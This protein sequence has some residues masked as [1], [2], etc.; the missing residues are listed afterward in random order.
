LKP[1]SKVFV[2]LDR[3]GLVIK[4]KIDPVEDMIGGVKSA[5]IDI[6][7]QLDERLEDDN[8]EIYRHVI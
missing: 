2:R 7:K 5:P 4:P 3:F 6:E 8:T 1:R